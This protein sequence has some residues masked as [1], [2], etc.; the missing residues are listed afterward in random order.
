MSK[1]TRRD[2]STGRRAGRS[3]RTS[4][5]QGFAEALEARRLLAAVLD[6]DL[7]ILTI[8]GGNE[9][10][11]IQFQ[12]QD[13]VDNAGNAT[14]FSVLESTTTA[15]SPPLSFPTQQ[16]ILDF[17]DS[18]G[19]PTVTNFDI[20][21]VREI[22]IN[23]GGGDDLIIMGG[24]LRIPASIDSG[25]GS[26][27]ISAGIGDDTITGGSGN[28][29][30]FGNDADDVL[31]GG[32]GGDELLGGDGHDTVDYKTRTGDL[33]VTIGESAN[34]GEN[35]END[36]VRTDVEGIIGGSGDDTLDASG[37][38]EGVLLDGADG[39]DT[40]IGSAFDDVLIG[41]ANQDNISG[42]AGDDFIP[43]E[44]ASA[45][46]IDGGDGN[47]TALVDAG[48]AGDD[49]VTNVENVYDEEITSDPTEVAG[50]DATLANG[51][52][53]VDGTEGDDHIIVQ[54]STDQNEV[55]VIEIRN[56]GADTFVTAF[57]A[58]DVSAVVLNGL[59]GDDV[60]GMRDSGAE[61]EA[62]LNGGA[63]NDVLFGGD[64]NDALD[65]GAGDDYLFGRGGDDTLDGGLGGDWLSGGSGNDSADYS[66]R[67]GDVLAGIGQIPDDGERGEGDN[68]QTDVETVIGGSGNDRFNTQF[69]AG[70]TF[71]GNDGADSMVG[72]SGNDTFF[73]GNG[74]DFMSGGAGDDSFFAQDGEIDTIRGGA[75]DDTAE[76]DDDDDVDL[77]GGE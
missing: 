54:R 53:T 67:T 46:D 2:R 6:S 8:T 18:G 72:G 62:V 45:D 30:I 13:D 33:T 31:G 23:S 69:T 16:Q 56:N 39:N 25:D 10:N 74:R 59:G 35:G 73:G 11:I 26:D 32:L 24:K 57:N 49:T 68:I 58:A 40:L 27:S 43:A 51:I 36:N 41:G 28:D 48:T 60:L 34:D 21:S 29:Y 4:S 75:G 9:K 71:F 17:I 55:F 61:M 12:V 47:D 70:V 1:H 5:P 42:G 76:A 38:L 15:A 20:D 63:G 64:A 22:R 19:A 50:G 14:T 3:S 37:A 77:E 52:I 65:G 44:D 66:D 7:G